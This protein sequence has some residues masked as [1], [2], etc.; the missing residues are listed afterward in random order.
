MPRKCMGQT[1]RQISFDRIVKTA[2][3]ATMTRAFSNEELATFLSSSKEQAEIV[4]DV[5]VQIGLLETDDRNYCETS[6]CSAFLNYVREDDEAGLHRLMMDYPIYRIFFTQLQTMEP[7]TIDQI[8]VRLESL[9]IPFPRDVLNMVCKW[10]EQI[11][12][13]QRNSVT[14]TYFSVI[15][16]LK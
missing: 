3:F 7:T 11:G 5:V 16:P 13:V 12:S 2:R 1:I 4:A 10:G 9:S 6:A 15:K 8:L 14:N